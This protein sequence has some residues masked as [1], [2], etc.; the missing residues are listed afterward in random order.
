MTHGTWQTNK[1]AIVVIEPR[2]ETFMVKTDTVHVTFKS[3]ISISN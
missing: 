3:F 2:I 1:A